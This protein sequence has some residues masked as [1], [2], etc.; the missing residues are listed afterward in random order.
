MTDVCNCEYTNHAIAGKWW[1]ARRR[2]RVATLEWLAKTAVSHACAGADMVAPSDM[3]DGRVAAIRQALDA[4]GF[5]NTLIF[6]YAAKYASV[7]YGPFREAA[8]S[9]P[10]F[11]DRRGYQ[12]DPANGQEALLEMQLDLDEGAD[13]LMVKPAGPYLD[14]IRQARDRFDACRSAPHQVSG[15]YAMIRRRGAKRLAGSRPRHDGVTY[16]HP[17]RG[18]PASSLPYFA[19]D[20]ARAFR[21]ARLILP[22]AQHRAS[23]ADDDTQPA[24]MPI[25]SRV[26]SFRPVASATIWPSVAAPMS[27]TRT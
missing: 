8:E 18:G 2:Q 23:R 13:L 19:P 27:S 20:V 6:S 14:V 25:T 11:G 4:H 24:P 5:S 21:P 10:Q 15:E 7:F 9:T 1:G 3:M 16:R 22:E 17:P 26:T 12:M